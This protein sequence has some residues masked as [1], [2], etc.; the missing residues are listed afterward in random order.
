MFRV[1][2]VAKEA[3][4]VL[5]CRNS[6]SYAYLQ[7]HAVSE[8]DGDERDLPVSA[9]LFVVGVRVREAGCSRRAM[10][11]HLFRDAWAWNSVVS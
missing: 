7:K 4:A 11:A 2:K 6:S 5:G 8:A 10:D 3:T 1:R 9:K